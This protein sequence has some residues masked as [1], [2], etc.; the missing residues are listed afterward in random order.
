LE[1]S[2]VISHSPLVGHHFNNILASFVAFASVIYNQ[3]QGPE[4]LQCF[5][6]I[7][8]RHL[9]VDIERLGEQ[10][11]EPFRGRRFLDIPPDEARRLVKLMN[12]IPVRVQEEQVTFEIADHNARNAPTQR[13]YHV[14]PL[15][16]ELP[17]PDTPEP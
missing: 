10:P 12:L 8:P 17:A 6:D 4:P 11:C 13:S 16:T 1:L 9:L 15:P 3:V 2:R 7:L 14:P 5:V